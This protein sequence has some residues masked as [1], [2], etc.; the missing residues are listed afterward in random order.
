MKYIHFFLFYILTIQNFSFAN[1]DIEK[2][3]EKFTIN[4]QQSEIN[5][6]NIQDTLFKSAVLWKVITPRKKTNYLFGTIHSQDYSVS[7]I[8]SDVNF[9]LTKSKKLILEIIPNNE[10]NLIYINEM[11]F[12]NGKRLDN[13]LEKSL[14]M[15]FVEQAKKYNL[16][17]KELKNIKYMK[18]WAA[19]N[20]IGRPKPTR[21]PTLE[22][23]LLKFA[24]KEM[25]EIDSLENMDDIIS[26][27]E[28]LSIEDQLNILRDT[29]CNRD[30][31]TNDI[32]MLIDFYIKRDAISILNLTNKKHANESI[33][34]RYMQEM[35]HNRNIKMLKKI[36]REFEKG[37][38]F[39]AVGILHLISKH[40]LLEK[41]YNQGYII[42]EI[43]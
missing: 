43:Y 20:L 5:L 41:L 7:K 24:K 28:K 29:V 40:G 33:Y 6:N 17:D 4:H 42:E 9:A 36:Y 35:L 1:D 21:A 31:I 11:Y 27:L 23:N 13:L 38:V 26:S 19:F 30:S 14:F 34:H 25:M 15:K 12:K 32:K 22:S 3:C 18:P 16:S 8:P 39:V 2:L 37:D 10:A